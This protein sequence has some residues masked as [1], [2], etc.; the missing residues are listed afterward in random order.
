M[1]KRKIR[2]IFFLFFLS[3]GRVIVVVVVA[4]VQF[5]LWVDGRGND[6]C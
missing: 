1:E 4:V 3:F 2:P 5:A 6:F